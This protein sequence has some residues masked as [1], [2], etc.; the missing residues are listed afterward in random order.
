MCSVTLV[1]AQLACAPSNHTHLAVLKAEWSKD[2]A[3]RLQMRK[4]LRLAQTHVEQLSKQNERLTGLLHEMNSEQQR[5]LA[6][7]DTIMQTLAMREKLNITAALQG[8]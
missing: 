1:L 3:E 2:E 5:M 8:Q 6:A 4:S 7:K